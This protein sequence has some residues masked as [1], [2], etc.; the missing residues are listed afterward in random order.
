MLI[1]TT[2]SLRPIT[3]E[4]AQLLADWANDPEWAVPYFNYW[5]TTKQEWE[6]QIAE[7]KLPDVHRYL[8]VDRTT[9]EP[10]GHIF[11]WNPYTIGLLQGLEIGYGVHQSFRRRGVATQ[12]ACLLVNHLFDATPLERFQGVVHP[13]NVASQ[14][15]LEA[16]GM[17]REG[18]Y[19]KVMFLHGR[20]IDAYLYS[21]VRDDWKDEACYRAGRPPF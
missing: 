14:R 15:V 7:P 19:R 16:A 20:F 8:I 4:N 2:V 12:A 10:M 1:G 3:T 11:Y 9:A 13:E 5:P 21:I 17:R 18:I 6:R